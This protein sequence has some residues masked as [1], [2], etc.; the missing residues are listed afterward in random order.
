MAF[1][2][3]WKRAWNAFRNKD[4]ALPASDPQDDFNDIYDLGAASWTGGR[5]S[6]FR[7]TRGN[8]RSIVTSIYNRIALDVSSIDFEHVRLDKDKDDRYLETLS[9]PLNR[10]FTLE[11]NQDQTAV[12]F[13]KD[14]TLTVM[15]E[16]CAVIFPEKTSRNP[17]LYDTFDI[18]TARVG[19]VIQ[20]YSNAV[21][22]EGWNQETQQLQQIKLPKRAVCIIENPFYSVMNEPSSTLQRLIRT[23]N[24]L[25]TVDDQ[26]A[27]GKLDLIMQMPYTIKSE[28]QR[29][30][31]EARI[32]QIENQLSGS[33]YGIAYADATERITQLNRPV[34]NNLMARVEYLTSML[35]SQLG[36][37]DEIMNGTASDEVMQNYY[38]RTV[39]AFADAYVQEVTRKWISLTAQTQGQAMR[40]FSDPFKFTTPEKMADIAD[41]FTRNEILEANTVRASMGFK[42]SGDPKADELRNANLNDPRAQLQAEMEIQ[43]Q[44]PTEEEDPGTIGDNQNEV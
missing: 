36:I 29:Q 7:F 11:A 12:A 34:E 26:S 31:A 33:K 9:S 32:Q 40:W 27:S 23:L 13:K 14:I 19:R 41:K 1:G 15:G 43:G 2:D 39:G 30:R 4:P 44:L 28:T 21:E 6:R 20:W 5:P 16:G 17:W 18:Y 37:T 24:A 3:R 10:I 42:P 8:E 22:I 35:Y 25:D 38:K